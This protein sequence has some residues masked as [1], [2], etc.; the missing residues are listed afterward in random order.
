MQQRTR[1]MDAEFANG[2]Q[3][4]DIAQKACVSLVGDFLGGGFQIFVYVHPYSVKQSKLTSILEMGGSTTNPFF[5][6][7]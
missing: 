6:D 5:S 3:K 2:R 1:W 7:S 4:N